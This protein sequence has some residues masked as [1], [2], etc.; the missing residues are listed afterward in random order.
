MRHHKCRPAEVVQQSRLYALVREAEVQHC[1]CCTVEARIEDCS[2]V[3]RLEMLAID[4]QRRIVHHQL[5]LSLDR[6][7]LSLVVLL[8]G[9]WVLESQETSV[10]KVDVFIEAVIGFKDHQ[11]SVARF[12]VKL[13]LNKNSLLI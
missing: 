11:T 13:L 5:Q 6:D 3:A 1:P 8:D 4:D 2:A 12:K 10:Y 7:Q 9:L